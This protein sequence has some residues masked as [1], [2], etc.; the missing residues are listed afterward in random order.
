MQAH[1]LLILM[2][3]FTREEFRAKKETAGANL[4]YLQSY[5]LIQIFNDD[6]FLT[7]KGKAIVAK[8]IPYFEQTVIEGI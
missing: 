3:L 7:E 4:E 1:R 5:G 2:F 8:V 6:M